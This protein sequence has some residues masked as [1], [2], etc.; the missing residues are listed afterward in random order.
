MTKTFLGFLSEQKMK[1][2]MSPK[3]RTLLL[4]VVALDAIKPATGILAVTVQALSLKLKTSEVSNGS[5]YA[6]ISYPPATIR[7]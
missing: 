2:S 5:S 3:S 6:N 1:R 7:Y 4:M